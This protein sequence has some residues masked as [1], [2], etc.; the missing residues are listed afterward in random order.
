MGAWMRGDVTAVAAILA[1]AMG[2]AWTGPDAARAGLAALLPRGESAHAA[3]LPPPPP[4]PAGGV[5][6]LASS[7]G[8]WEEVEGDFGGRLSFDDGTLVATLP[9]ARLTTPYGALEGT[10]LLSVSLGLV[11]WG[12]TGWH[13]VRSS[14]PRRVDTDLVAHPS[15][16]LDDLRLEIPG[17]SE[18][19][20]RDRSLVVA[21][22]LRVPGEE[23]WA[24][25]FLYVHADR[26]TLN[27]L[28]GWWGEEVCT[29]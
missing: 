8:S 11:A 2:A 6:F 15:L 5:A 18:E 3:P 1:G 20:L 21:L 23:G 27:R 26:E 24:S 10:R 22:E 28:L 12:P 25:R 13:I 19:E 9:V 7:L 17:L 4:A 29:C 16:P 14:E